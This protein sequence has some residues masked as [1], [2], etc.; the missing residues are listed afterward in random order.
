MA[1]LRILEAPIARRHGG[2]LVISLLNY[3]G[4]PQASWTLTYYFI[5]VAASRCVKVCSVEPSVCQTNGLSNGDFRKAEDLI[6]I[7]TSVKR[8]F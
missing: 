7:H 2:C 3:C 4:V 8:V 5:W 1:L 6:G